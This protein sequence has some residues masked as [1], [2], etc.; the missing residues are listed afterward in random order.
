[1]ISDH[2]ELQRRNRDWWE[3]NPMTYDWARTL[4]LQPGTPEFYAAIDERFFRSSAPFGHPDYPRQPPFAR[5]IDYPALRGKRVLEIGCGAG[6]MAA[7]FAREGAFISAIDI[8]QT[9]V[10]F[11]R[12]RFEILGLGG[13]IRPMD[14]EHLQFPDEQFDHVWSWGVIHHSAA[15][16]AII[17]EI[18]RVLKPGGKAQV[19][20]YHRHSLRNW[21]LAAWG[22]G[23]LRGKFLTTP[24]D[25][26]LRSV[27]DGYIARHV[28]VADGRKLFAAFSS[29]RTELTDLADLS[30]IPGNVQ[31]E[32]YLVGRVIPVALK[33]RLDNWLMRHFGW[34][35]YIEA[36]K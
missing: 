18:H 17:A 10:D 14:A 21:I 28:S 16:K 35:L 33:R 34:F 19:M 20:I 23:I 15:I 11:T 27:T 32:K 13:D 8:T 4:N 1:M 6:T 9:A 24:Y 30:F 26:I 22:Q 3:A 25:E 29:V 2:D 5:Q 12:R 7:A 31:V 36:V